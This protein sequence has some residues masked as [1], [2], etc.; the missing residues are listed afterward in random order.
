MKKEIKMNEDGLTKAAW[1]YI[2]QD[3]NSRSLSKEN[4]VS[5]LKNVIELDKKSCKLI[6][7]GFDTDSEV[8][9]NIEFS[10]DAICE[11][12]CNLYGIDIEFFVEWFLSDKKKASKR[13]GKTKYILLDTPEQFYDFAITNK[14]TLMEYGVI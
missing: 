9:Q 11:M 5:I 6:E 10:T 7:L 8:V 4:F 12:L 14:P 2:V 3:S 13:S 1:N